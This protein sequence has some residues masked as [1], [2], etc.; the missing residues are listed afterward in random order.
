M[1]NLTKKNFG[2]QVFLTSLPKIFG[3][4]NAAKSFLTS[5]LYWHNKQKYKADTTQLHFF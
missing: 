2:N 3:I 5:K 4:F 1:D